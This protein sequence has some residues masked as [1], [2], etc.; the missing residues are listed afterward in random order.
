M[1]EKREDL[2]EK[3]VLRLVDVAGKL[4]RIKDLYGSPMPYPLRHCEWVTTAF[5]TADE[6]KKEGGSTFYGLACNFG[7]YWASEMVIN[8]ITSTLPPLLAARAR[9]RLFPCIIAGWVGHEFSKCFTA[10]LV[11]ANKQIING[12][13]SI[14]PLSKAQEYRHYAKYQTR[15]HPKPPINLDLKRVRNL[16]FQQHQ[17]EESVKNKH[18]STLG[19]SNNKEIRAIGHE[20]SIERLI[21]L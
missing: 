11:S 6:R 5:L 8:G 20:P 1:N 19:L 12:L 21:Y 17:K 15:N 16:F 10:P 13:T 4:T 9:S 18:V 3:Y 7:A 14:I 2:T